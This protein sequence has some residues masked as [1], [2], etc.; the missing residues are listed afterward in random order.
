[1]RTIIRFFFQNVFKQDVF[2]VSR[3]SHLNS[4]ELNGITES[5]KAWNTN[6]FQKHFLSKRMKKHFV[7][8]ATYF[9]REKSIKY[10]G[11]DIADI[12]CGVGT[13]F[14]ILDSKWKP[15]SMTGYEFSINAIKVA[16][17]LMPSAKFIQHDIYQSIEEQY[18]VVFC[19]EVIEHL[20]DPE[21]AVQNMCKTLKKG[22]KLIIAV[23]NA[24][25][26]FFI[27]HVNFWSIESLNSFIRKNS[28]YP[29]EV[30][31]YTY[32]QLFVIISRP[33]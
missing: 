9:E 26:D 32:N 24:R 21:I 13:M 29:Y 2:F 28:I 12:G 10:D 5:E 8:F 1:M 17:E 18:D 4:L 23:P 31:Y 33:A 27:G 3:S 30:G 11:A 7:D 25:T 20:E 22:G 15:K 16:E 6:N 14:Y 19:H